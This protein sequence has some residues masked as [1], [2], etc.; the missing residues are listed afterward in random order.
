M[1]RIDELKPDQRAALQLLL[2]QGRSYDDIASLLRIDP[3][4]VRERARS[5]LDALGPDDVDGLMLSDQDEIADYLLGQQSASQR[6]QTRDLLEHSAPGRAWARVVAGELRDLAP[7]AL[8]EIPADTQEVDDAFGA[9]QARTEHRERA[10]RSSKVGGA[11]LLGAIALLV[12]AVLALV[13][14]GGGDDSS[15]S[16]QSASTQQSTTSTT[17]TTPTIEAQI[18]LNPPRGAPL[19]KA[20]GAV[21]IASQGGQRAAALVAQGLP[22]AR[23]GRYFAIWLYSSAD[24]FQ[25]LGFPRP[26][27]GKDGRISTSFELKSD[28]SQYAGLVVTQES[29]RKPAKPGTIIL[30]GDFADAVTPQSGQGTSTRGTATQGGG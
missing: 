17:S 9:L 6:A 4:A 23:Q 10:E 19:P 14:R 11:I 18:N 25:F 29:Q 3:S 2:K 20:V 27:P 15:S 22:A 13:L 5:A 26:Q 21:Q 28:S 24:K 12:A 30:R 16:S 8:P 1:S 7:D